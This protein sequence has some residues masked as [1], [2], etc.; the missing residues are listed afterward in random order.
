[1]LSTLK[2]GVF[3]LLLAGAALLS[4]LPRGKYFSIVSGEHYEFGLPFECIF[5]TPAGEVPYQADLVL[6][7]VNFMIWS[8][9]LV[10]L[11]YL[12]RRFRP[13]RG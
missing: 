6:F 4:L 10:A 1:M 13:R 9:I 12:I 5:V 11:R 3:Y 8:G 2:K 7:L